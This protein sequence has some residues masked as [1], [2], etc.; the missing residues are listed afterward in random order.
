MEGLA[1]RLDV[2]VTECGAGKGAERVGEIYEKVIS[3][4]AEQ[5]VLF[6]VLVVGIVW[7]FYGEE[8]GGA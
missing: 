5:A 1:I 4:Y 3:Y 7:V 2:G 6:A 8:R